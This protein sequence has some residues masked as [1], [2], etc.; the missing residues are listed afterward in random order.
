MEQKTTLSQEELIMFCKEMHLILSS[1]VSIVDGFESVIE[2]I[3]N[4]DVKKALG[5]SLSALE[6]NQQ[7]S[8]SLKESGLFSPYMI[9]MIEIGEKTGKTDQVMNSLAMYYEKDDRLKKQIRS[10]MMYPLIVAGMVT[11]IIGVMITKVLPIFADVFQSLGGNIPGSVDF[12]TRIGRG[13]VAIVL[14]AFLALMALVGTIL[15]LYKTAEGR[16][17]ARKIFSHLPHI[18]EIYRRYQ[19]AHFAN[20][21]SLLVSSGY[22]LHDSLEM[23]GKII[24]DKDFENKIKKAIADFESGEPLYKVLEEMD[25]F[26]GVHARMIRLSIQTGHLDSVLG[27]LSDKYTEDVDHSISSLIG[28]IEPTLVGATSFIIGG[29]LL[30]VMLPLLGIMSSMG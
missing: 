23:T 20:S 7:L 29:I 26:S 27:E 13:I 6:C 24:D 22:D 8:V 11:V 28:V 2:G 9:S 17:K 1:S 3:K 18:R 21:L 16:E 15:M 25:I 30:T 14:V 19:T 12:V 4:K 5:L 10:S